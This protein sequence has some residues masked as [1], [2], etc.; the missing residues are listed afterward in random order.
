ML[1]LPELRSKPSVCALKIEQY[2]DKDRL[3]ARLRLFGFYA[4]SGEGAGSPESAI[5]REK[6]G[7]VLVQK[8]IVGGCGCGA[9]W[10][11]PK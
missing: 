7:D 4:V 10:M 1:N 5:G 11:S 3:I 2:S 8:S 6:S 9:R